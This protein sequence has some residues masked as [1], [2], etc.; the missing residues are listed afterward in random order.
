MKTCAQEYFFC[1][2]LDWLI[3]LKDS[4]RLT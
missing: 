2:P 4:R 1:L 3:L